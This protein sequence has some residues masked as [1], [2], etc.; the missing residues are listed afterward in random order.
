M[1]PVQHDLYLSC[2]RIKQCKKTFLLHDNY[3]LCRSNMLYC[4]LLKYIDVLSC[5]KMWKSFNGFEGFCKTP[6]D[7]R[8]TGCLSQSRQHAISKPSPWWFHLLNSCSLQIKVISISEIL[9]LSL[10]KKCHPLYV[11]LLILSVSKNLNPAHM[12][13]LMCLKLCFWTEIGNMLHL[14]FGIHNGAAQTL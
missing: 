2:F 14:H 11:H 9:W 4:I 5:M 6:W 7:F 8:E 12:H 13:H 10:C 3:T 1:H